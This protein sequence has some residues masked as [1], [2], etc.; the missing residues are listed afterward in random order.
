M[1]P[2]DK[3]NDKIRLESPSISAFDHNIQCVEF[4]YHAHGVDVNTLNVYLKRHGELGAPVWTRMRDQG[5]R[6]LR[7]Q[8]NISPFQT[9][10]TY[11]V[12]FESV[13]TAT[14]EKSKGVN[15]EKLLFLTPIYN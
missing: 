2:H 15:I 5:N 9:E 10:Q 12:V 3:S 8:V 6:W 11:S 7:G 13:L 4:Y 14:N 1:L